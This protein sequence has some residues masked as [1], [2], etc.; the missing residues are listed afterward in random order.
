VLQ[1]LTTVFAVI[2]GGALTYFVQAR[3]DERRAQRER[4]R[5]EEAAARERERDDEAA[6]R[7]REREQQ[8]EAAEQRVI[9]RLLLDELDTLALHHAMLAKERRYPMQRGPEAQRFFFPTEVWETYKSTLARRLTVSAWE[10]ITPVMHAAPRTRAIVLEAEPESP[11]ESEVCRLCDV[12]IL[13]RDL[14]EAL[15]G[16]PAPSVNEHGEPS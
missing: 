15:A 6:A 4:E 9:M 12:A 11:I 10:A 14:Y 5:D 13:A 8:A 2:V 16:T 7:E 1:A 3:L